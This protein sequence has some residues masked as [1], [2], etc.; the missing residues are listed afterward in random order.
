MSESA[1][2]K[3]EEAIHALSAKYVEE[4]SKVIIEGLKDTDDP[5][6]IDSQ[7][8]FSWLMEEVRRVIYHTMDKAV[9]QHE[10]WQREVEEEKKRV[11]VERAADIQRFAQSLPDQLAQEIM[12]REGEPCD[13][14]DCPTCTLRRALEERMATEGNPT[15]DVDKAL[16]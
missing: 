12:G 2:K 7:A 13:N 5:L 1:S 14:P 10:P 11:L 8:V 3:L 6:E 16:N 4:A 9:D 15:S